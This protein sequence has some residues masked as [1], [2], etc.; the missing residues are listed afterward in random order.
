MVVQLIDAMNVQW[1][2]YWWT[3]LMYNGC[4]IEVQYKCTMVVLLMETINV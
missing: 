3:L 4:T 2:Y 1:L